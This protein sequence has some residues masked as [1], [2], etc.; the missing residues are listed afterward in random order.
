MLA[1]ITSTNGADSC[2][3]IA[4][5]VESVSRAVIAVRAESG[6][7]LCEQGSGGELAGVDGEPA[8]VLVHTDVVTLVQFALPDRRCRSIPSRDD[9]GV[10]GVDREVVETGHH[11]REAATASRASAVA[12]GRGSCP[13][14][15]PPIRAVRIVHPSPRGSWGTTRGTSGGPGF[16]TMSPKRPSTNVIDGMSAS[17]S[18]SA[19]EHPI[20]ESED[21]RT[22][23]PDPE[24]FVQRDSLFPETV[25]DDRRGGAPRGAAFTP[26]PSIAKPVRVRV[27]PAHRV[28]IVGANPVGGRGVRR[29]SRHR[30]WPCRARPRRYARLLPRDR[31]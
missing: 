12:S 10:H 7:L 20:L 21:P 25:H 30:A 28:P 2:I 17:R 27:V 15:G 9:P 13:A 29:G 18:G 24:L 14:H 8:V 3:G 22:R 4:T 19:P 26:T 6:E 23:R 16:T 11:P 1:L 5:V 31:D